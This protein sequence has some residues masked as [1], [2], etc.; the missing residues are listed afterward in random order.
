MVSIVSIV[1]SKILGAIPGGVATFRNAYIIHEDDPKQ[2]LEWQIF[3][4]S[5]SDNTPV[6]YTNTVIPG[7]SEPYRV[8]AHSGPRTLNFDLRFHVSVDAY[9]LGLPEHVKA[10]VDWLRSLAYPQVVRGVVTHP[11]VVRIIVG[12][13]INSRCIA[14]SANVTYEGPWETDTMLPHQSRVQLSFE[15]TNLSP[16][17]HLDVRQDVPPGRDIFADALD[18]LQ[19]PNAIFERIGIIE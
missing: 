15:E 4:E 8:Y 1:K 2:R 5:I 11:P 13:L 16:R 18:L 19:D 9:D 12:D 14:T 6:E 7:R 3:P 10:R 17:T